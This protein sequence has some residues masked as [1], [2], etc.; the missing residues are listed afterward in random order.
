MEGLG[1]FVDVTSDQLPLIAEESLRARVTDLVMS[2]EE[3]ILAACENPPWVSSR[4]NS[5][6]EP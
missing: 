2:Y 4:I 5:I 6:F 1:H 3:I